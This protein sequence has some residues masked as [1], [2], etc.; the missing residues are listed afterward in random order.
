MLHDSILEELSVSCVVLLEED[1]W[2]E[3]HARFPVDLSHALLP[4]ADFP[5][6]RLNHSYECDY[7]PS[8][9]NPNH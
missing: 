6:A 7:R 2:K 8:P 5:I 4:F 9:V 3:A 1:S